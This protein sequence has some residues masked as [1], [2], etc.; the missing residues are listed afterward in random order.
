MNIA[1]LN[2][3][4]VLMVANSKL[5]T[6]FKTKASALR[7]VSNTLNE[8]IPEARLAAMGIEATFIKPDFDNWTVNFLARK[9]KSANSTYVPWQTSALLLVD[10]GKIPNPDPSS[11]HMTKI[12]PRNLLIAKREFGEKTLIELAVQI[13]SQNDD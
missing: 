7:Q 10:W 11:Q 1:N 13:A 8:F 6:Q 9:I 3:K 4:Q 12:V 5:P 2:L